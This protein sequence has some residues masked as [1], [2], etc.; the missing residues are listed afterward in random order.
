MRSIVS[1]SP[2]GG[3]AGKHRRRKLQPCLEYLDR[4]V[5]LKA[6]SESFSTVFLVHDSE[7]ILTAERFWRDNR[8]S[9]PIPTAVK[10]RIEITTPQMAVTVLCIFPIV[11]SASYLAEKLPGDRARGSGSSTP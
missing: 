8:D 3:A 5:D 10:D 6:L 1:G 11:S 7:E 2:S 4:N 9:L